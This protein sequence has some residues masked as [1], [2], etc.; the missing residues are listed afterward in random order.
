MQ[1][2]AGA[3]NLG[4]GGLFNFVGCR[5]VVV[6][7]FVTTADS[8]FGTGTVETAIR[9]ENCVGARFSNGVIDGADVG[10]LLTGTGANDVVFSNVDVINTVTA[11]FRVQTGS[12]AGVVTLNGCNISDGQ[13]HLITFTDAAAF[14]FVLNNCR[15]MNAGL[16]G[17]AGARNIGIVTSGMVKVNHCIIGQNDVDADASHYIAAAGSGS[18]SFVFPTIVGS[19]PTAI[20]T[21]AQAATFIYEPLVGSAVYD[22]G[23]LAD[24][25]GVTTTVTVTGAA[26]GDVANAA[27][28][29]DLQGISVTAY[30]SAA[31]TVSVRFQNESGGVLDLASGTLTATAQRIVSL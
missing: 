17:T 6:S 7:N 27:F 11:G 8:V 16:G 23:S 30:V 9:V 1:M 31:N 28:S 18:L 22:P 5:N 12:P 3:S 13:L 14:D 29:L 25:A 10:I 4:D 20:K 21:G 2:I 19:P 15:L 26:L 24:A